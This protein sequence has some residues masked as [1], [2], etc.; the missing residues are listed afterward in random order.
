M[1]KEKNDN[2]EKW[3]EP[4]AESHRLLVE[5]AA[6]LGVFLGENQVC[7][8]ERFLEELKKWNGKV[9]LTALRKD[10]DI[11]V[12]HFLDS[13][14]LVKYL[15]FGVSLLDIGSGAGFPGTPLKI[16]RPDISIVLLEGSSKKVH[17]QKRIIRLLDL[18][19][20]QSIWGRS[21]QAEIRRDLENHFDVVASRAVSSGEILLKE[22]T[23]FVRPG[24]VI[25]AMVGP[26]TRAPSIPESL[27][28]ILEKTIS[29]ELP[30]DDIKRNLTFYRKLT[31]PE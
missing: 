1:P 13:L 27:P 6:L 20:I 25:A 9:N 5:G 11:V 7:L 31:S 29:F 10:R 15:P 19:G 12:K 26:Q 28:I 4:V 2:P 16:A 17:F 23:P 21:D 22:A 8:F 24:G 30:F 18:S 14:S 3:K